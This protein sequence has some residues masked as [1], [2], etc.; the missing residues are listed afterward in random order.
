MSR[1]EVCKPSLYTYFHT[2][3]GRQ[4]L[5]EAQTKYFK[6]EKGRTVNNL[7]RMKSYY[8]LKAFNDEIKRLNAIEFF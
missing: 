4:H 2:E 8:K 3:N 1:Y 5:K 6:S 7:N